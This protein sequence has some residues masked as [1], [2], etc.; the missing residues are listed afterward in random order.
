MPTP[1]TTR[2]GTAR[3]E[4]LFGLVI[5]V[6]LRTGEMTHL[7]HQKRFALP[8]AGSRERRACG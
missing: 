8:Q 3:G 1:A 2:G 4:A 7:D 6:S 5:Q